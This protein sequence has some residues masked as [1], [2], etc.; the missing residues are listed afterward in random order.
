M[1]ALAV[2]TLQPLPSV[3]PVELDV[4]AL[5]AAHAGFIGRLVQRLTGSG[6]HVDDLLQEVFIVAYK[7]RRDFDG[8]SEVRTWLYGIAAN[9]C[10]RHRRGASRFERLK[11]RLVESGAIG[12]QTEPGAHEALERS[13]D[14]E[15][16]RQVIQQLP[17]KQREVFVLFELE[18]LEGAAI[19]EMVGIPLGTVWT[20]LKKA[21]ETFTKLMR[22][23]V[24]IEGAEP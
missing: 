18:G 20:R 16:V 1:M 24:R 4:T 22:R 10:R 21:R 14:L 17:F 13:E 5:Y 15:A 23:K 3:E 19:A 12:P 9:L 2:M 7:R 8:S 11:L 6:G